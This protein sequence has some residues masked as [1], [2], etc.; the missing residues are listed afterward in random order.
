[1]RPHQRRGWGL[2]GKLATYVA[3]LASLGGSL[4]LD[5]DEDEEFAAAAASLPERGWRNRLYWTRAALFLPSESPWTRVREMPTDSDLSIKWKNFAMLELT[6]L[7]LPAFYY[8]LGAFEVSWVHVWPPP[9]IGV[10]GRPRLLDAAGALALVLASLHMVCNAA[11]LMLCFGLPPATLSDYL[12]RARLALDGACDATSECDVTWP[13][14]SEMIESVAAINRRH[15]GLE[16][17]SVPCPD[18]SP[19][20]CGLWADGFTARQIRP[21][22]PVLEDLTDNG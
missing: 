4:Q 3:A 6:G 18:G 1:M 22:D 16:L 19:G 15:P 14:E 20:G 5:D 17:P 2:A 21:G 11:S 13:S 10:G 8:L 12:A 9:P 7:N